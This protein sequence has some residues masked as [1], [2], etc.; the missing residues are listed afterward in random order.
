MT[1]QDGKRKASEDPVSPVAAKRVKHSESSEEDEQ[2]EVM[3][4]IPFPEKVR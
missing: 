3:K 1:S 4:P 2:K